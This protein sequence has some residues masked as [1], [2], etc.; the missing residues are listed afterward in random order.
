MVPVL[1]AVTLG[2]LLWL[3][4][5][6]GNRRAKWAFKPATSALFLLAAF[7]RDPQQPYD[8]L[9][10]AALLLS[11]V[12]DVALIPASRRWF[13]AGLVA[14]LLGH[15]AYVLAFWSRPEP[16][17]FRPLALAAIAAASLGTY[18]WLRPYLGS[19]RRPVVA[20]MMVITL[21]LAAAGSLGPPGWTAATAQIALAATLFYVSDITVA[22]ARFVPGTGFANRAVGLPLYYTAQFLF[23]YSVGM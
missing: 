9:V 23:A 1:A 17:T 13:L 3:G 6:A 11:A 8:W 20:Y 4:E 5:R 7:L 15:V 19:L 16:W 22:R 12:G 2:L 21:M 14:F 18:V 10:V